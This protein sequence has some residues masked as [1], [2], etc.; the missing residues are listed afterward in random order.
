[1][2]ITAT[3]GRITTRLEDPLLMRWLQIWKVIPLSPAW[4]QLDCS[5]SLVCHDSHVQC[6]ASPPQPAEGS[7]PYRQLIMCAHYCT[8]SMSS[9]CKGQNQSHH[10][11]MHITVSLGAECL[12]TVIRRTNVP[13]NSGSHVPEGVC[14]TKRRTSAAPQ[15][16]ANNHACC[17]TSACH[18]W[19]HH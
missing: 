18:H 9:S 1:M 12:Q 13:G 7:Q 15:Q 16:A 17:S 2:R 19:P 10:V 4:Q 8:R 14:L 5:Y 6:S 11:C 3:L